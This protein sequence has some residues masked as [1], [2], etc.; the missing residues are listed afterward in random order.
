MKIKLELTVGE[1]KALLNAATMMLSDEFDGTAQQR[2]A[3][4]RATQKLLT[5]TTVTP[6]ADKHPCFESKRKPSGKTT[7]DC[8][9]DGWGRCSECWRYTE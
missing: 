5:H 6:S 9:G 1:T 3:L 8:Y 2:A 7:E 4:E